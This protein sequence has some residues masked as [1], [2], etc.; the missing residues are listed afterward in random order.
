M[1]RILFIIKPGASGGQGEVTW[2]RFQSLWPDTIDPQDV[3]ITEGPGHAREVAASAAGY[4]TLATVGGDGTV[5]EIM[6]G[7]MERDGSPLSLA[8]IP[9]GT[10]NDIARALGLFPVEKAVSILKS[11]NEMPFDLIRVDGE[12]NGRKLK[13]YSLLASGMGFS[14]SAITSPWAKRILGPKLAYYLNTVRAILAHR[15]PNM[16]VRWG[17]DLYEGR[18]WMIITANVESISGGSMRIAPGAHPQDGHLWVTI[19]EPAP[20][21]TMMLKVL[22][23][24]A[25]GEHLNEKGFHF[26]PTERIEITSDV[27]TIMDIDGEVEWATKAAISIVP[28]AVRIVAPGFP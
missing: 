25:A 7:I 19:V 8:I 13:R 10:G 15:S 2:N 20:K 23:K 11:G 17:E 18:T 6:N 1:R 3:I 16:S 5:N 26:F 9:A 4:D 14:A 28:G 24:V 12:E 27:P 22:P 21:L